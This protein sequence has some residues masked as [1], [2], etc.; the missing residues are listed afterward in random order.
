MKEGNHPKAKR[1][2]QADYSEQAETENHSPSDE[3][4]LLPCPIGD[5]ELGE[6]LKEIPWYEV[7]HQLAPSSSHHSLSFCPVPAAAL[8]TQPNK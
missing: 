5:V 6:D 1:P 7:F 2:I 4:P 8:E 3:P